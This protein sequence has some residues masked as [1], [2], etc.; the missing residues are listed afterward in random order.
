M[1]TRLTQKATLRGGL[2]LTLLWIFSVASASEFS[3][4]T[5]KPAK[6]NAEL[7]NDNANQLPQQYATDSQGNIIAIPTKAQS[8]LEY[9]ANDIFIKPSLQKHIDANKAI[10]SSAHQT[11]TNM[12]DD[13]S[14]RWLQSRITHLQ[15]KQ[16]QTQNSSF[17]HYQDEIDIRESEWDC[18]KC[19]TS[20]PNDVDR[21]ECQHKR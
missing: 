20:G 6:D 21:G 13:P 1:L 5:A 16:R 18:L 15:K 4:L 8:A 3:Q 17:S 14:C 2:P 11:S 19:A 7:N 10:T 9:N 12:A